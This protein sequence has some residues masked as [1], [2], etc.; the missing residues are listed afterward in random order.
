MQ[1]LSCFQYKFY[2]WKKQTDFPD[3]K[4]FLSKN[5]IETAF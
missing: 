3:K 4:R 2:N 1:E 5:R